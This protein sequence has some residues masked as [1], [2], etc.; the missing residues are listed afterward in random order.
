MQKV[1][2]KYI[3]RIEKQMRRKIFCIVLCILMLNT[4]CKNIHSSENNQTKF[5]WNSN[6]LLIGVNSKG[7]MTF[8]VNTTDI[9]SAYI[10][11]VFTQGFDK[12]TDLS[13]LYVYL[14]GMRVSTILLNDKQ[15][16]LYTQRVQLPVEYIELGENEI[17]ISMTRIPQ[18]NG[19]IKTDYYNYLVLSKNTSVYIEYK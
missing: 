12:I 2:S 14:N 16:Q 15:L 5:P 19:V 8:K 18:K 10:E 3:L 7:S 13:Y 11:L 6:S 4:T 17:V 1:K 9:K